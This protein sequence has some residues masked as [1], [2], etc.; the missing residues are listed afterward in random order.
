VRDFKPPFVPVALFGEEKPYERITETHVTAYYNLMIPYVLGSEVFGPNSDYETWILDTLHERGG[1]CMGMVRSHPVNPLFVRN[2]A[3]NN[4]YTLRYTQTLLRRD[5]V[6]RALV[7]FYGK[8]AQ[9]MAPGTFYT[10]E[11]SGIA[12]NDEYGRPFYLPPNS[13]GNAF[14]LWMLRYMLIQDWDLNDDGTPETL[15][16][17]YATPRAWLDDGKKITVERAPTAFGE[18]SLSVESRLKKGEVVARIKA[19]ARN[20]PEKTL[21]RI[22]LP[23]GHE[24]RSATASGAQLPVDSTG[25]VDI[26]KLRGEFEVRFN[27]Q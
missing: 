5:E 8:L 1:I 4:L 24:I 18:M 10:G 13:A 12:P 20:K 3:V 21:L 26:S 2:Q 25:A 17:L 23:R 6:D 22:R 9:A 7:S 19:P 15:R 14:F 16:L 27:V 11:A